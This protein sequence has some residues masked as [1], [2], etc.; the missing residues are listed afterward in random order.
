MLAE[1]MLT[2]VLFVAAFITFVERK[3]IA[4]IQRRRGPNVYEVNW[5]DLCV[6]ALLP[7]LEV[8]NNSTYV[9]SFNAGFV[10]GIRCMTVLV[11]G[12]E[13]YNWITSK[14]DANNSDND[15]SDSDDDA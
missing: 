11:V 3:V 8:T 7:S 5:K 6:K 2:S 13:V 15:T 10:V 4:S 1:M 9:E 14:S 12:V